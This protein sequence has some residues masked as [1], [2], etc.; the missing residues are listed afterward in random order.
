[1]RHRGEREDAGRAAAGSGAVGQR[2]HLGARAVVV[3][4]G[5]E[6]KAEQVSTEQAARRLVRDDQHGLE[7]TLQTE[8]DRLQAAHL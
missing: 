5:R 2:G 1:M 6:R 3:Q 8:D 4:A 7:R